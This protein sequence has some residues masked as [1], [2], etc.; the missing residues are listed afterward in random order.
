MSINAVTLVQYVIEM[1]LRWFRS[2]ERYVHTDS[3]PIS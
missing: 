1:G 3:M 2:R